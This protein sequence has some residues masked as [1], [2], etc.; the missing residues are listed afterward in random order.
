[1]A[2][3]PRASVPQSVLH[4]VRHTPHDAA[5]VEAGRRVSYAEFAALILRVRAALLATGA[6][7]NGMVGVQTDDRTLALALLVACEI[8]GATSFPL[9]AA[10]VTEDAPDVL[11][12]CDIVCSEQPARPSDRRAWLPLG[13]ATLRRI[14]GIPVSAG[15][16][17]LLDTVR[18]DSDLLKIGRTSGSSGRPKLIGMTARVSRAQIDR[19]A[20]E[21]ALPGF[22]P[23]V[24]VLYNFVPHWVYVESAMAWRAGRTVVL[25]GFDRV[26]Q[27][28]ARFP[29][30][31]LGLHSGDVQRLL[32][33]RPP[34]AVGPWRCLL[35]IKG[36]AIPSR[37]RERLLQEVVSDLH[38]S[39]GITE[40]FRI[41]VI[42]PDGV[43]HLCPDAQVRI[44]APDGTPVPPGATGIIEVR[45]PSLVDGYLWDP[46][47]TA[48]SFI[49][50]WFRTSDSGFMPAPDRLVLLG[51]VDDMLNLGGIKVA[52][53]PLEDAIR[54][55]D[56]V[57]D[58]ILIVT[59]DSTGA[60]A[61]TVGLSLR[62]GVDAGAIHAAIMTILAPHAATF[63]AWHLPALP[64]TETGKPRRAILRQM[65]DAQARG[66]GG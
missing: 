8:I 66:D 31:H 40:T 14:A 16:L 45:T 62:D 56:G 44:V 30:C 3:S 13:D 5:I 12:R 60:D 25:S 42:D 32:D 65:F 29:G 63:V 54:A 18:P 9:S 59:S 52:P 2:L 26:C 20:R 1:M 41:S 61:L 35:N 48:A 34:S 64:R 33:A 38:H 11:G 4:W 23:D 47:A 53:E 24:V 27:D 21:R 39:Y 17:E 28:L 36:G 55:I 10:D 51:R 37:W 7:P 6:G 46:E 19:S 58:A 50:G 43:G 57:E 22:V 15:D 49:D